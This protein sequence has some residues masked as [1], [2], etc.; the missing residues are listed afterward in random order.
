MIAASLAEQQLHNLTV[1]NGIYAE[2]PGGGV[3]AIRSDRFHRWTLVS[4][5]RVFES[6][7]HASVED[8]DAWLTVWLASR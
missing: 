6:R 5:D 1:F 8:A 4:R 2:T 3:Y 7:T